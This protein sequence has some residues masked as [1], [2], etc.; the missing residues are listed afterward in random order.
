VVT[1]P[2]IFASFLAGEGLLALEGNGFAGVLNHER[3]VSDLGLDHAPGA[4][5]ED[6]RVVVGGSACIDVQVKPLAAVLGGPC[7]RGTGPTRRRLRRCRRSR[8][9]RQTRCRGSGRS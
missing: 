4:L 5:E 8:S 9:S 1:W 2:M 6:E 7:P 3:A